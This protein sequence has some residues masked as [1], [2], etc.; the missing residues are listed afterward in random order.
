M[1]DL[2]APGLRAVFFDAVGTLLHPEP[3]AAAAYA[4]IGRRFGTRVPDDEAGRRFA[5]AFRRQE[6][7]DA[8]R[9]Y[10]TSEEREERRWR[11]IVAEVLDDVTDAEECFLAL[12]SHFA[13]PAAWRCDAQAAEVLA[14]LRRRGLVVGL[15]SNFDGRLRRVAAGV[16]ELADVQHLVISSEVGWKKPA[17]AFFA[18]VCRQAGAAPGEVLVVGDDEESDYRGAKRAGLRAVLLGPRARPGKGIT[19]LRE[20][21]GLTGGQKR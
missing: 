6:E 20:L 15:A 4:A 9:G 21:L 12:H 13:H 19:E 16:P 14:A 8:Q 7:E 10:R 5:A 1:T 18:A 3:P 11:A 17:A 2:L